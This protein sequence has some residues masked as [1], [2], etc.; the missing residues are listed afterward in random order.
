MSAVEKNGKSE[1]C[2]KQLSLNTKATFWLGHRWMIFVTTEFA[3]SW[4][5]V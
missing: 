1:Y 5:T 2:G 4:Q 3:Q